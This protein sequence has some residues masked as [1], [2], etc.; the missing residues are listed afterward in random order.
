MKS[1]GEMIRFHRVRRGLRPKDLALAIHRP[2]STITTWERGAAFPKPPSIFAICK[3][4]KITPNDLYDWKVNKDRELLAE[5][6]ERIGA[7]L[8]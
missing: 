5:L 4:L 2:N 8:D 7:A 6:H 1:I 3:V